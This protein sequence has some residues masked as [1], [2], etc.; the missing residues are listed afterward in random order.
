[1]TAL[2]TYLQSLTRHDINTKTPSTWHKTFKVQL[3]LSS[4]FHSVLHVVNEPPYSPESQKTQI[5]LSTDT[6]PSEE[7]SLALSSMFLHAVHDGN[8]PSSSSV[9]KHTHTYLLHQ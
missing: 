8:A 4:T 2:P 3:L 1:M 5:P 6:I 7:A 9:T